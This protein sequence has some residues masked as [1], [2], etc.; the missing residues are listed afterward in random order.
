MNMNLESSFS[1]LLFNLGEY[2]AY[3]CCGLV[4]IFSR[5]K[6]TG[7]WMT[8]LLFKEGNLKFQGGTFGAM[9]ASALFIPGLMDR[10][11]LCLPL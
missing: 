6:T 11:G 2:V 1:D 10:S 4:K 7:I 3:C 8:V 5:C 9:E